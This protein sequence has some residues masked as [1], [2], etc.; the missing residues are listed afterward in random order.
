MEKGIIQKKKKEQSTTTHPR[1][2]PHSL[3][4]NHILVAPD[5]LQSKL[6]FKRKKMSK[7]YTTKAPTSA[8]LCPNH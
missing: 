2:P 6:I 8:I 7:A 1:N 3:Q 5:T 4:R